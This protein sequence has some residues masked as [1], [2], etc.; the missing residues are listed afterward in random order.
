MHVP[1]LMLSHFT[2]R[3]K[4]QYSAPFGPCLRRGKN[5]WLFSTLLLSSPAIT[6]KAL[7]SFTVH[8]TSSIIR[9]LRATTI[10]GLAARKPQFPA[11]WAFLSPLFF[12]SGREGKK[13][14]KAESE[15]KT[16]ENELNMAL[17]YFRRYRKS[18][19]GEEKECSRFSLPSLVSLSFQGRHH[20]F[21]S[22]NQ[23]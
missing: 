3:E 16:V 18:S 14:H 12:L 20:R 8:T 10:L 13:S 15:E 11:K 1:H 9:V 7:S 2:K 4:R 23:T 17:C 5:L 19:R 22:V 21:R 6:T